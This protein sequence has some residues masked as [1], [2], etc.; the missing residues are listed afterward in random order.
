MLPR[1]MKAVALMNYPCP[2]GHVYMCWNPQTEAG[3]CAGTVVSVYVWWSS[4]RPCLGDRNIVN[5]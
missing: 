5:P 1:P 2:Q 4:G 3:G